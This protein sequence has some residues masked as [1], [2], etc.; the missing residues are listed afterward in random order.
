MSL[1]LAQHRLP[2]RSEVD[3]AHKA[4]LMGIY[5]V[6]PLRDR[7]WD[8]FVDRHPLASVF[9]RAEWLRA[10]K[11]AYGYEPVAI[12][13]CSPDLRLTQAVVFCRVRSAL[14][15]NRLVSLPFSDHCEPLTSCAAETEALAAQLKGMTS[16]NTWRYVEMRTL[17]A[18]RQELSSLGVNSTYLLHRLSLKGSVRDLFNRFHKDCVR[19]KIAR[20][21]RESLQYEEGTSEEHLRQFY[22]L[23]VMTRRRQNL[24]PQPLKWFRSLVTSFGKNLKIRF[25]LKDGAPIASILTLSHRKT[26][27]YKYGCSDARFHNLGGPA[28]LLWKTIQE[29]KAEGFEELDLGRTNIDHAGL[30][31]FKEHWGAE[32][33]VLTY[34]RYPVETHG[35][36]LGRATG[37]LK[38]IA[39]YAPKETLTLLGSVF[40]RHIG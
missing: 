31:A 18:H 30:I 2:S 17:A 13:A 14:T 36:N 33:Q 24:P 34:W 4:C 20:A 7:R 37:V 1:A 10:L 11:L 15:G 28:F 16:Q 32:R 27:T 5:E 25:A 29:A 40:Y 21:E 9:H 8:G 12:T 39:P 26:V 3:K 23:M 6:D 35:F 19:R 22:R 38:R